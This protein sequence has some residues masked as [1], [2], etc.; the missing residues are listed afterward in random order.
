MAT[1]PGSANEPPGGLDNVPPSGSQ[2]AGRPEVVDPSYDFRYALKITKQHVDVA[3]RLHALNFLDD[4]VD[5]WF[6][7]SRTEAQKSIY[8]HDLFHSM[9]AAARL[10][11]G[12][13]DEVWHDG[14]MVCTV[15]W[16]PPGRDVANPMT[17]IPAGVIPA[18]FKLGWRGVKRLLID[19]DKPKQRA[20]KA[21]IGTDKKGKIN[22]CYY[23]FIISTAESERGKGLSTNLIRAFQRRVAHEGYPIWTEATTR[24]SRRVYEKCGFKLVEEITL[25]KGEVNRDGKACK[26]GE[27]VLWHAMVWYPEKAA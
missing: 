8:I 18:L 25:G 16:T 9:L 3:S 26:G 24:K 11:G 1:A 20:Q 6:F 13:C 15:S 4:P 23:M 2:L 7:A 12:T 22:K 21:S 27:G 14:Q 10:N 19:I 17:L 5:N